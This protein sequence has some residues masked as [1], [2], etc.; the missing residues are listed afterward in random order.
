ML[1]VTHILISPLSPNEIKEKLSE[2]MLP[3]NV[4]KRKENAHKIL[5]GKIS[6]N[7]FELINRDTDIKDMQPYIKGKIELFDDKSK[8]TLRFGLVS[9]DRIVLILS[10][11]LFLLCILVIPIL[12]YMSMSNG[13]VF[14]SGGLILIAVGYYTM[15]KINNLNKS[16]ARDLNLLIELFDSD[17]I[18]SDDLLRINNEKEPEGPWKLKN[19]K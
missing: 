4:V 8:I 15:R 10:W 12:N 3:F 9:A 11:L 7:S 18:T 17:V 6:G 1:H 19:V 13:G 16:S 2:K 5:E 14:T